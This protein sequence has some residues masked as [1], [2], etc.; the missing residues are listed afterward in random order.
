LL[1]LEF[2]SVEKSCEKC[3]AMLNSELQIGLLC[4]HIRTFGEFDMSIGAIN[5]SW[6][7]QSQYPIGM[8]GGAAQPATA[9]TTATAQSGPQPPAAGGLL[10]VLM[11]ALTNSGAVTTAS[12]AATAATGGT[13]TTA[14]AAA[15][16]S[17][18]STS[19]SS[20]TSGTSTPQEAMLAFIQNLVQAMQEH[21]P[22]AANA[23]GSPP[24]GMPAA[25]ADGFGGGPLSSALQSLISE[26]SGNSSTS[27]A[28]GA[29]DTS[30][31]ATSSAGSAVASL[32]QSFSNLVSSMGGSSSA[33]LSGFLTNFSNDLSGMN[34]VG[35]LVN[36]QA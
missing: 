18:S 17:S 11:Q 19:S 23:T 1:A 27:T 3:Q 5:H 9:G 12:S 31:A 33:S 15:T 13:T 7:T 25:P 20:T 22:G 2:A 6:Q 32:Q 8:I 14:S 36:T 26:V 10:A 29:T 30:G 35:N 34:T 21:A 16:D 24:A 28:T 4:S